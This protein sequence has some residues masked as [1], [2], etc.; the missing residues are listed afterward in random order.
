MYIYIYIIKYIYIYKCIYR[1]MYIYIQLYNMT[2]KRYDIYHFFVI[3]IAIIN[4]LNYKIFVHFVYQYYKHYNTIP[5]HR[6]NHCAH[7]DNNQHR[8]K[9]QFASHLL[10]ESHRHLSG[11]KYN[12][13]VLIKQ[14]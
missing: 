7:H 13:T 2:Y 12:I 4:L 8:G 11:R 9:I 1:Y 6:Y 10:C 3:H 5:S 14:F